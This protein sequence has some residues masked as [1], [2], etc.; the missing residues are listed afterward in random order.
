MKIWI[1]SDETHGKMY[2]FDRLDMKPADIAL[3]VG[4]AERGEII[5]IW[6]N[7]DTDRTPDHA[8][9]WDSQHKKYRPYT[10]QT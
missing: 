2:D 9:Y 4:R 8:F 1:A 5:H 3:N 10:M 6:D 7:D